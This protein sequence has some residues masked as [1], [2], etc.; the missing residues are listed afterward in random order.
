MMRSIQGIVGRELPLALLAA[1]VLMSMLAPEAAAQARKPLHRIEVSQESGVCLY[2]I[3]DQTDQDTFRITPLGAVV[4]Q[5]RGGVKVQIEIGDA[6]VGN[7]KISGT[8]NANEKKIE[9]TERKPIRSLAVRNARG[10]STEHKVNIR[11]CTSRNLFGCQWTEARPAP[12]S[13]QS[14]GGAPNWWPGIEPS[15]VRGP[16]TIDRPGSVGLPSDGKA[17]R[18]GPGGPVMKIEEDT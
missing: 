2:R 5:A 16:Q 13:R 3:Q 10:M 17:G 6:Q 15:Q 14:M 18:P 1:G 9:V 11:C 7:Q 8:A 4:F 12:P